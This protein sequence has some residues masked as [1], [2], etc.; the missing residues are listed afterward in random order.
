[1]KKQLIAAAVAGAFALP[2]M[3]QVTISGSI[4]FGVIDSGAAGAKAVANNFGGGLNAMNIT[5]TEDLGGGMSSG[6]AFQI[7]YNADGQ[8]N[9][10]SQGPQQRATQP[11]FHAANV[12]LR[13]NN[14][15]TLRICKIVE[16]SNCAFDPWGCGG[17]AGSIAGLSGTNTGLIFASSMDRSI[18]YESPT[19][20]G[21]NFNYHSTLQAAAAGQAERTL[22]NLTYTSGPLLVQYM[23]GEEVNKAE[24]SGMGVRYNFGFMTASIN[25]AVSKSLGGTKTRDMTMI[26]A[27]V[28]L[29]PGL[30]GLFGYS[31]DN[32]KAANADTKWGVGVD[33]ALSKRTVVGADIFEQEAASGSTGYVLRL[34]HAY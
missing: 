20:N 14:L 7:R 17:G 12:F 24:Q 32:S 27:T 13:S 30:N 33:Y 9:S 5:S 1:M 16:D 29:R 10:A 26:S 18:R 25:T 21:F 2:A 3:A 8:L 22:M 15:G 31:R 28:P 19:F 23:Q 4:Q 6:A 11:L 34:R